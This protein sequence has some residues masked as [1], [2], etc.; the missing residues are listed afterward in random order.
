MR[1]RM[2]PGPKPRE[3]NER[4]LQETIMDALQ[5][6]EHDHRQK[7]RRDMRPYWAN[8][9]RLG[10]K[11]LAARAAGLS[12][13]YYVALVL[14]GHAR[15]SWTNNCKKTRKIVSNKNKRDTR[16]RKE[17]LFALYKGETMITSGTMQ[18]ISQETGLTIATLR[19]YH[20][21]AY[22]R[23][24]KGTNHKEVFALED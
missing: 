15:L 16:G 18:E 20:S 3:E 24:V 13:G 11:A 12:Y 17:K 19:F 10:E 23:R 1:G 21:P 14:E 6:R 8:H 5:R 22:K 9:K 4:A 7:V 2:K